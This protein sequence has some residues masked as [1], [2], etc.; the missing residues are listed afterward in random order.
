MFKKINYAFN[1]SLIEKV[2]QLTNYI[3]KQSCELYGDPSSGYIAE[4]DDQQQV[5][6][7][8]KNNRFSS[9]V[10]HSFPL[11]S[12][13][14]ELPSC[15][16]E[17]ETPKINWQVISG[18][19]SLPAHVDL[20]RKCALNFYFKCDNETTYFYNRKRQGVFLKEKDNKYISNELFIPEWLEKCD[21]FIANKYDVYLLNTT[22]PHSVESSKEQTRISISFSYYNAS[23]EDILKCLKN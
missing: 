9:F 22:V 14:N 15:F 2:T 19:L 12:F 17:K 21:E 5:I 11:K 18:G 20:Q 7:Y 23:F 16:F 13:V 10:H 1:D 3:D 6:D 4:N 8:Y